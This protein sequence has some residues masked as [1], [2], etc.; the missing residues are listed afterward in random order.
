MS[1]LKQRFGSLVAAH[2]KRVGWTQRRLA[3]AVDLSDDTIA[4]I[5]VGARGVSFGTIEKLA[6]ALGV[7]PAELFTTELP[8][9][10]LERRAAGDLAAKIANVKSEDVPWLTGIVEAALKPK[11]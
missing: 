11:R 1:S 9:G 3:E 4:R 8:G 7:D 2:R 10:A 5:E 6:A